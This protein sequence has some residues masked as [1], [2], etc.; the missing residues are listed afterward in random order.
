MMQN[1]IFFAL[2]GVAAAQTACDDPAGQVTALENLATGFGAMPAIPEGQAVDPMA[3]LADPT[4]GPWAMANMGCLG[5]AGAAAGL[6]RRLDQQDSDFNVEAFAATL[7]KLNDEVTEED[8]VDEMAIGMQVLA[9]AGVNALTTEQIMA[10]ENP[11]CT[12]EQFNTVVG[13]AG[14]RRLQLEALD[15]VFNTAIALG[16]ECTGCYLGAMPS[17]ANIAEITDPANA[18]NMAA[19]QEALFVAMGVVGQCFGQDVV[20]GM[21]A[22]Q[23]SAGMEEAV[24]EL[25]DGLLATGVEDSEGMGSQASGVIDELTNNGPNDQDS[26]S[27][28][29]A[30]TAFATSFL[31]L[32]A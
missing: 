19:N 23:S 29:V 20:D 11:V 10:L 7:R 13:A 32:F 31:A 6:T 9:C 28:L 2:V 17:M 1:T 24:E 30:F 15:A 25:A 27:G 12:A 4:F 8:V 21:T 14:G 18:A 22:A 26:A 5:C 16:T 3:L